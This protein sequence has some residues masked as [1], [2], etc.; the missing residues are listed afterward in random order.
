M[1]EINRNQNQIYTENEIDLGELF[2]VIWNKKFHIAAITSFFALFSIVYAL[3]LPNIYRS[4][5]IMMPVENNSSSGIGGIMGQYA[6]MA[7]LA[8]ISLPSGQSSKSKE[9]IA[10]IQSFE[11]FSNNFLPNIMLENLLAVEKWN[12]ASNSFSYDEN[13]FNSELNKWVRKVEPPRSIIPSAQEAYNAYK[14]IMIVTEDKKTQFVTF[15]IDHQSPFVAQK[16]VEIMIKQIDQVM[17]DVDRKEATK[18]VAY[19]NS[20]SPKVNY[21]EVKNALSSLQQEQVKRLMMIE[22]NENYIFKVLDS[23]IVPERKSQPTRSIIVIVGTILGMISSIIGFL[24]LHYSSK[25]SK[26]SEPII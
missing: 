2:H 16:W 22:A 24:V 5:A 15:S 14:E 20:L 17:R 23:P 13:I 11:F 9:A 12:Q 25:Y 18:S 8:G 19:L 10:R 26:N 6:S 3:M 7:S 21:G 4:E 1:K